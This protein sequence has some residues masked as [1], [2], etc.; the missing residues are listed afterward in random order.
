MGTDRYGRDMLSRVIMGGQTTIF[1]SLALVLIIMAVGTVIGYFADIRRKNGQMLMRDS[2]ILSGI[3]GNG[4]C[5][6]GGRGYRGRG[7]QC[8][9]CA[10]M[11]I[12]AEICQ[13]RQKPG[14]DPER[15]AFYRGSPV[16]RLQNVE[17]HRKAYAAQ[18]CRTDPY[19]RCP[20]Y[21]YYDDGDRW[22][23]LFGTG[24][25]SP[26]SRVGIYDEQWK[27]YASDVSLGDPCPGF[28]NIF[29]SYVI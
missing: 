21:R 28:C 19:H 11:Y 18:Y 4:F 8:S 7:Y 23:V 17:D 2:D 10:G 9:G 14:D 13:D 20:G 12:L 5:Y 1:S 27:E 16:V 6:C 15:S 29:H 24:S 22:P 3:S 25:S 26:Y